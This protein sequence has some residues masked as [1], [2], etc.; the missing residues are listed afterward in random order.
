[1]L[2]IDVKDGE[3]IDRA[4][5][6]YKQKHRRVGVMK[7]LRRRKN[8]TKPSVERRNEILNAVYRNEKYSDQ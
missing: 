8:F 1:M 7:E 3:S 4:L 2:I 5:K 6:R